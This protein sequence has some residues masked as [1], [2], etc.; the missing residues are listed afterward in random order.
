[1]HLA[2]EIAIA[3]IL[4]FLAL[5]IG[6]HRGT[7]IT[8]SPGRTELLAVQNRW[9]AP[10]ELLTRPVPR[11]VRL[12]REGNA[13]LFRALKTL[14]TGIGI[15]AVLLWLSV[16]DVI[17]YQMLDRGGVTTNAKILEKRE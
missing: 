7:S 2:L 12:T 4:L 9:H 13:T 8:E 5:K 3:G 14:I 15:G 17:E 1:M 10:A 16:R 6:V 11:G